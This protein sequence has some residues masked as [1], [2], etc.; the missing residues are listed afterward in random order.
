MIHDYKF[1]CQKTALRISLTALWENIIGQC[2]YSNHGMSRTDT[3]ATMPCD[4]EKKLMAF[5]V[6]WTSTLS[7]V[8]SM[9]TR[10]SCVFMPCRPNRS[11]PVSILA[12]F[13]NHCLEPHVKHEI[14]P[15][16][17][18]SKRFNDCDLSWFEHCT[19]PIQD[20]GYT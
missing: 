11:D 18:V 10:C 13:L 8:S 19:I 3:A 14:F 5:P 2:L 17:G 4:I 1:L 9:A 16:L 20:P 7:L 15:K 12:A 6:K